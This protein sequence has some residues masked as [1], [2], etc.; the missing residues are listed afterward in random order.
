MRDATLTN[1]DGMQRDMQQWKARRSTLYQNFSV[2]LG[3]VL[4]LFLILC[5]VLA[6]SDTGQSKGINYHPTPPSGPSEGYV[7]ISYTYSIITVNQE[8]LWMFDW[9]DGT[10]TDWLQLT[11]G[12]TMIAQS[13]LWTHHGTYD[14]RVQFKNEYYPDGIWS[15]PLSVSIYVITTDAY[16]EQPRLMTGILNGFAGYSYVFSVS[17][18]DPQDSFLSYRFDWGDNNH[19]TGWTTFIP[20]GSLLSAS[21]TWESAGVYAVKVQSQNQY[22]LESLWSEPVEVTITS[23]T[24]DTGLI[25]F[26]EVNS[27]RHR[28][29]FSSEYNAR[30]YNTTSGRATA[31]VHNGQGDFLVDDDADGWADYLYI[32]PSG[33][34]ISI[35]QVMMQKIVVSVVP[36][37]LLIIA[38]GIVISVALII[39]LL[40][41]YGYIYL[42]EEVIVEK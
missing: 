8:S 39:L 29:E 16:P 22:G 6:A 35:P 12:E 37:I 4:L 40:V 27:V 28:I 24:Q 25:T 33:V 17:T 10:S 19:E 15:S 42:Y 36:M 31:L 21:C 26:V 18:T 41:K 5:C 11:E 32:P 13:H 20:S 2:L 38:L 30:F 34:I 3:K 14:V 1:R 23:Q 9:G 7:N